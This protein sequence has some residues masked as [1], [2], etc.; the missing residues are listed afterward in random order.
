MPLPDFPIPAPPLPRIE[1]R[2]T[3]IIALLALQAVVMGAGWFVTFR[4]VRATFAS[5]IEQRV[6]QENTETLERLAG[7]LLEP[8]QADLEFGSPAWDRAQEIVETLELPGD[9]FACV[10]DGSGNLICHPDIRHEPGLRSVNLGDKLITSPDGAATTI[11]AT[12]TMPVVGRV[13]FVA[14]GT[15]FIATSRVEG[16]DLRVLVHQREAG[17]LAVS[18]EATRA[19]AATAGLA[20]V[21]VLGISGAGVALVVRRYDS[22]FETLNRRLRENLQ[23]ARQ[24]QQ[25]A[26]PETT[27]APAGYAIAAWSEPAEETGGD[28]FDVIPT[29]DL[30]ATLLLADATGHGVGPALSATQIRA[31]LRMACRLSDDLMDIAAHVNDQ[32]AADLPDG[33]FITAWLARLD[34]STHTVTSLAAGQ[35]PLLHLRNDGSSVDRLGPDDVPMGVVTPLTAAGPTTIALAPGDVLAVMS[36][37][38]YEAVGPGGG[39][40]L[41]LFGV[42][43]AAGVLARHAGDTPEKIVGAIRAEVDRF[44]GGAAPGDDQTIL[45]LKRDPA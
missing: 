42:D 1:R 16:S 25:S 36:D 43:R 37:G 13:G 41:E 11:G 10:I 21:L 28:V 45:V 17:L 30:G 3:L 2:R 7:L 27:D 40:R 23:V 19:I 4:F 33:R 22:V 44:T 20:A 38:I 29:S 8:G 39:D 34:A 14:D 32:L 6:L 18:S 5:T 12:N 26:L 24:I 31:M 15:H 9:G 35:A